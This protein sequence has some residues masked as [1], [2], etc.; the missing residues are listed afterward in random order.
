NSTLNYRHYTYIIATNKNRS[1]LRTGNIF[2][3]FYIVVEF[4]EAIE[5]P[6]VDVADDMRMRA[7]PPVR[8]FQIQYTRFII[9][10]VHAVDEHEIQ[11]INISERKMEHFP[12]ELTLIQ[13]RCVHRNDFIFQ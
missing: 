7:V 13:I 4:L 3:V 11:V 6:R 10:F 12:F 9:I 5:M 8:H 2:A 1:S